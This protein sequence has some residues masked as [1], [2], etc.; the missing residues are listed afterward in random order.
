MKIFKLMLIIIILTP[1]NLLF[2]QTD[3]SNFLKDYKAPDFKL[4]RFD[5]DF[6]SHGTGYQNQTSIKGNL[7][8]NYQSILNNQSVQSR[9]NLYNHNQFNYSEVKDNS[10]YQN[11]FH[12]T[13]RN[14]YKRRNYITKKLFYGISDLSLISIQSNYK[15][16]SGFIQDDIYTLLILNPGLSIGI[17]RVEFVNYAR[18][19]ENITRMLQKSTFSTTK[20]SSIQ[21][22]ELANKIAT[23]QNRRFFDTRLNRI[24]QIESIDSVLRGMDIISDHGIRYFAELS[25]AFFYSFRKQRLSGNRIEF[26]L[27]NKLHFNKEN[28]TYAAISYELYLPL[29][30]KVQ[31]DFEGAL[32]GSYTPKDNSDNANI[33]LNYTYKFGFYPN[34]RTYIGAN[35]GGSKNI[36]KPDFSFN[37]GVQLSYY[38][39]PKFRVN[40]NGRF[41]MNEG[42]AYHSYSNILYN[43]F[44]IGQSIPK[45]YIFN[46]GV[47]Y[48][49]F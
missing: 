49:I 26:I 46:I 2:G 22:T 40:L 9:H 39:S 8:F 37:T 44:S 16:D 38:I 28:T 36:L 7:R 21:K 15:S 27:N 30:Y 35:I 48:A 45:S 4:K 18:Q 11:N 23:I 19:S 42:S 25:D 1:F 13:I 29:S 3:D 14:N 12:T 17:G 10:L 20:L 43:D 47:N 33:Y 32:I 31:H 5:I 24:Y 6:S 34:T 41:V